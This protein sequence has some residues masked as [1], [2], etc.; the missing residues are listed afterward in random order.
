M[1]LQVKFVFY[2]VTNVIRRDTENYKGSLLKFKI[3]DNN[4][5]W[6]IFSLICLGRNIIAIQVLKL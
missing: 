1:M 5:K 6:C 3:A 4:F 2:C